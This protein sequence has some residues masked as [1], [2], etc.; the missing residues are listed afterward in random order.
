MNNYSTFVGLDVHKDSISVAV[1]DKYFGEAR[2]LGRFSNSKDTLR[3]IIKKLGDPEE[4]YFCY[5]AGPCGYGIYRY[6]T[7]LGSKCSVIAP[8]LI[9]KRPGDRVKTD[10]RDAKKLARL[11]RS[12]ELTEVWV[13]DEDSEA[14]R[15]LIRAREAAIRDLTAKRNQLSK[16]LLRLGVYPPSGTNPWTMKYRD[17]LSTLELKHRVQTLVLR[18]YLQ[19]IGEVESRIKRLEVEIE[20][21]ANMETNL[22]GKMIKALQTLRGV[23]LVTAATIVAETGDLSRFNTAKQLM[24]YA[25]LVPSEHSSGQRQSR[26]SITKCGNSRIRRVLVEAAWHYRHQPRVSGTLRRRQADQPSQ[27]NNI[28]WKAQHRLNYK[29]RRLD[30]RK[31]PNVVAVV[32][33]A[34]E[35]LGFIWAIGREVKYQHMLEAS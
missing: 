3:K 8:S 21:L 7:Y 24:S 19:A 23:G 16:L 10:R 1:A 6:L 28:S 33:V 4:L 30:R 12:G 13:P 29:Y 26:G 22:R 20:Q 9:P 31:K 34:R 14:F 35:L 17:W 32:A 15:D 27:I 18:E 5:E 2:Y 11:L 25:G